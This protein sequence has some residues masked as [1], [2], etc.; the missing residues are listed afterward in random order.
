MGNSE[1]ERM[2][3]D[4]QWDQIIIG[5]QAGHI[6]GVLMKCKC[7]T[8]CIVNY[9]E[10]AWHAYRDSTQLSLNSSTTRLQNLGGYFW[11]ARSFGP[12]DLMIT[13]SHCLPLPGSAM[14]S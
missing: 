7:A 12:P 4:G 10:T 5:R 11:V 2:A 8:S 3:R 9:I 13:R 6:A 14:A 1:Y